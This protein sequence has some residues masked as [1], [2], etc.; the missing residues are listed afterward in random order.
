M[1]IALKNKPFQWANLTNF[2]TY[3]LCCHGNHLPLTATF[4]FIF[5][6]VLK[7]DN[8]TNESIYNTQGYLLQL[9]HT[10]LTKYGGFIVT[11]EGSGHKA[12]SSSF[13]LLPS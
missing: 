8:I 2:A 12:N 6:S 10:D 7:V 3:L 9:E 5:T 13:R 11:K 1:G 4:F